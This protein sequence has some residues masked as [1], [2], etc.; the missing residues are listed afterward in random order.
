MFIFVIFIST[1]RQ[2]HNKIT[3]YMECEIESELAT[4]T[5]VTNFTIVQNKTQAMHIKLKSSG[6]NKGT[7]D[8]EF[9]TT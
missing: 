3:T 7:S 1:R 8:A 9:I 6:F 5:T 4:E 2:L